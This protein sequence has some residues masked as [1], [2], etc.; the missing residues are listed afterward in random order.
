MNSVQ[1][2]ELNYFFVETFNKIL[3]YE[4]SALSGG[5]TAGL[6]VRELHILE[7][8]AQLQAR[9]ENTMTKIAARLGISVGALTTAVGV[10]VGKGCLVR[11]SS[12]GDRRVVRIVLTQQGEQAERRHREFHRDMVSMIG[13][14]LTE[15]KLDSLLVSLKVLSRF[16]EQKKEGGETA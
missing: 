2:E 15:E 5:D 8:A 9:G 10:L 11:E 3:Q 6:S 16:F 4:E 7:A 1:Q 13:D 12:P 14:S